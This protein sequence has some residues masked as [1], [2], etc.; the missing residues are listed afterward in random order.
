M[1][2]VK[3]VRRRRTV[4]HAERRAVP[5]HQPT[6]VDL[7]SLQLTYN[8]LHPL[9]E[10]D[11]RIAHYFA[12]FRGLGLLLGYLAISGAKSDIIFL[13]SDTE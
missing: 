6:L 1:S 9:T 7:C 8:Y 10:R 4:S 11:S 13:L 12:L 2:F 5:L 3:F